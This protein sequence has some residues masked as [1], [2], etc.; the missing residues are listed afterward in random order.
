MS[1]TSMP[2]QLQTLLS[3]V[4][5]L[6][7]QVFLGLKREREICRDMITLD[8][9]N[10]NWARGDNSHSTQLGAHCRCVCWH[11]YLKSGTKRLCPR[12]LL[13]YSYIHNNYLLAMSVSLIFGDTIDQ[14]ICC[15]FNK[16]WREDMLTWANLINLLLCV[17]APSF[18][19]TFL[20]LVARLRKSGN[21]VMASLWS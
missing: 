3:M 19:G 8:G 5:S 14:T 17:C 2:R 20:Y 16:I 18:Q 1:S 6:E 15:G 13:H 21:G 9:H 11:T 4:W 10:S 7:Q 12:P